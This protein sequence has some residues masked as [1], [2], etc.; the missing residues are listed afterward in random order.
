MQEGVASEACSLAGH[1][2]LGKLIVLYDDNHITIDG[3]TE[4]SFTE[5]V[6]K[7][8][9]AY[10]WHTQTVTTAQTT[11]LDLRTAIATAKTITDKPSIIKV[12]TT[13]GYGSPSKA[14]THGAHGAPLGKDD[15]AGTKKFYG[16]PADKS[17]YVPEEVYNAFHTSATTGDSKRIEWDT[18]FAKYTTDYP[19]EAAELS[20]RF[21]G[22]LPEGIFDKLPHPVFGK[23]PDVATRKHS[24][25]CLN[26]IAPNLPELI[27][28]SADLTPST[29][30]DYKGVV[31]I[32]T[33]SYGGRYIRFGVREHA[34][35][36]ICNGL[37]AYGG[38]RPY[39]A[40]FLVF[41]GYCI[42][43]IRLSALSKFGIIFVFTHDSIGVG[44]DGPTH[45]PIETLETLRCLPNLIVWRPADGT[46]T[47][48]GYQL[49]LERST[50]PT[51]MCLSRSNVPTLEQSSFD[52]AM[53]GAYAVLVEETPDLII[54]ASGSE[55][56]PSMVGAQKLIADGIKVRVVSMPSQEI[57]LEQSTEYKLSVLPGDV[58]TMSVEASSP[59]GWDK[60]SH[61]QISMHEYGRSG[62]GDA[63][64]AKFGFTPDNI[65]ARGLEVINYYKNSGKPV[66][67]LMDR[68]VFA[69]TTNGH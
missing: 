69:I 58:P 36:S 45:Q 49:A 42:G 9:D 32:N 43:A 56:G 50:T 25:N 44:E 23:D 12:K 52:H 24:Q 14:G 20:R 10:G 27:G 53:H 46:E 40:T 19:T 60:F 29:L 7:R 17:F 54:I 39:C 1:L 63:V 13:I 59:H 4:L 11:L 57:F 21:A 38:L 34:M 41:T 15:L 31:D 3:H 68:P 35:V 28:G 30:T 65:A 51:V 66:P 61:A 48:A 33:G 5:D 8:F 2:G 67:N 37:F 64:F 16:L 55:V 6:M 26:G 62:P 18:M 47:S 22:K